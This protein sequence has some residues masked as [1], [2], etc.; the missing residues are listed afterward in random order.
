MQTPLKNIHISQVWN[1][2][3]ESL[4]GSLIGHTAPIFSLEYSAEGSRI[5]SGSED[6]TVRVW[7]AKA[8]TS[9]RFPQ[10][11]EGCVTI[12]STPDCSRVFAGNLGGKLLSWNIS[13]DKEAVVETLC[14]HNDS[15]FAIQYMP[16]LDRVVTGS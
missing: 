5:V 3:S 16:G 15:I 7:D 6:R 11:E 13:S 2:K 4:A 9:Y 8:F 10:I 12:S 1:L 14:V